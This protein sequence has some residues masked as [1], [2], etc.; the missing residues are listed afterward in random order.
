MQILGVWRGAWEQCALPVLLQDMG[1]WGL[2]PGQAAKGVGTRRRVS[3]MAKHS[4]GTGRQGPC[5]TLLL[6]D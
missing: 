1:R 2:S 4:V 3:G 5:Q 6:A